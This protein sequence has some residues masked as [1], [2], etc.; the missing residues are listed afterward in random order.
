MK[1]KASAFTNFGE[2]LIV[3]SIITLIGG[4]RR[5]SKKSKSANAKNAATG[6]G[7]SA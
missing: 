3:L 6:Q 1:S 2:Y 5:Y 4:I 7:Y